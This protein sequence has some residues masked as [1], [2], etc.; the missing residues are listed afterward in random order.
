MNSKQ[1]I[2]TDKVSMPQYFYLNTKD[3]TTGENTYKSKFDTAID[4]SCNGVDNSKTVIST[5]YSKPSTEGSYEK[6]MY[7]SIKKNPADEVI[8]VAAA[9]QLKDNIIDTTHAKNQIKYLACQVAQMHAREYSSDSFPQ[10]VGLS[11]LKDIFTKFITIKPYLIVI[12]FLSMFLFFQGLFSSMDVGYNIV[13]NLFRGT[14]GSSISYWG[15]LLFGIAIPFLIIL[16]LFSKEICKGIKRQEHYDITQNPF[17]TKESPK[18]YEK[19]MDYMMIALFVLFI[20]GFIGVLYTV[21]SMDKQMNS[22]V[23]FLTISIL[24]IIAFFLYIFYI[25][26]PYL[27]SSGNDGTT[28]K[29]NKPFSLYVFKVDDVDNINSNQNE[30]KGTRKVF[31]VSALIIYLLAML[32]FKVNQNTTQQSGFMATV[33]KGMTSAGAILVLPI[34]WVVNIMLSIKYFYIYPVLLIIARGI[35]YFVSLF[36]FKAL[37]TRGLGDRLREAFSEE[38]LESMNPNEMKNYSPSWGLIGISL[39]KSWMN[40]CGFD[41]KFS[42]EIVEESNTQKDLSGNK[43]TSSFI[44]GRMLIKDE[45]NGMDMKFTMFILALT[46]IISYYILFIVEKVQNIK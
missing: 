1:T 45:R 16:S 21:G 8:A 42:K 12:F 3:D 43:Y 4:S 40:T 20:Y 5:S 38:F 28:G 23:L 13:T 7:D 17:G 35:R 2:V 37:Q 34:I 29:L 15:G 18:T 11:N 33:I 24:G 19:N 30:D 14:S 41:N 32:F 27:T 36:I 9:G 25:Y 6:L 31:Q 44:L 26:T 22:M 46:V 10:N 39:L